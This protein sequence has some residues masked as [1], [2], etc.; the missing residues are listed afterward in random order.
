MSF[1]NPTFP[2]SQYLTEEEDTPVNQVS[3]QSDLGVLFTTNFKF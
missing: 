3:E 1:D 2:T